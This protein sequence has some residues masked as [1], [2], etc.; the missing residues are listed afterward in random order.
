MLAISIINLILSIFGITVSSIFILFW[1]GR[2]FCAR[3]FIRR[4]P[5]SRRFSFTGTANNRRVVE[6][7]SSGVNPLVIA[8]FPT[9]TFHQDMFLP[10]QDAMCAVCLGEYKEEEL[11]RILP[12]CGHTFHVNCIDA[13]LHQHA[14]CPVCRMSLQGY[15]VGRPMA[16]L[17][18]TPLPTD[19]LSSGSRTLSGHSDAGS[20]GLLASGHTSLP[21]ETLGLE[22]SMVC[23]GASQF[24]V[25]SSQISERQIPLNS[26][27]GL[28]DSC[29]VDVSLTRFVERG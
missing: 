27:R 8:Y 21:G 29:V 3:F 12:Q 25:S 5:G 1:C 26:I 13:W 7:N 10:R 11:L 28:T 19:T 20:S 6:H 23:D 15:F 16:P 2:Y 18:S 14:T 17:Q 22:N 24:S 9:I 4:T